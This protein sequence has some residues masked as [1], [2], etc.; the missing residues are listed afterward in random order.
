ME[1]D[2]ETTEVTDTNTNK[3]IIPEK[4]VEDTYNLLIEKLKTNNIEYKTFEVLFLNSTNLLKQVK[5][6]QRL[7]ILH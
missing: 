4:E 1:K 7:E 2:S 3:T 5:K 6:P